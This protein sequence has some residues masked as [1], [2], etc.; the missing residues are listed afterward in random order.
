MA[1]REY[2]IFRGLI[3]ELCDS[4]LSRGPRAE[5]I[6]AKFGPF[7]DHFR[8]RVPD[9]TVDARIGLRPHTLEI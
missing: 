8:D 5:Q 3:D 7:D 6:H 2:P 4:P 9:P 1:I